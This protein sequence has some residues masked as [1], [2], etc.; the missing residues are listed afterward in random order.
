MK[1]YKDKIEVALRKLGAGAALAG[2][3]VNTRMGLIE[4]AFEND[5]PPAD[6]AKTLW[7]NHIE[8]F[9]R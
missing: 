1:E 9:A 7:N 8:R 2:S 3:L 6:L 4:T 5:R